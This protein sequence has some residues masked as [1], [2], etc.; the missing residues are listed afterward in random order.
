MGVLFSECNPFLLSLHFEN[1]LITSCVF[2]D[3]SL[4]RTNFQQCQIDE[5]DF[6]NTDLTEASFEGSDLERTVFENSNLTRTSFVN[7]DNYAFD[8]NKNILKKT[9][10]SLPGALSLL[11]SFDV[12]IEP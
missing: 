11:Y 2:S 9:R 12:V 7:A 10:L 6:I 4:I 1:C 5:C 8:P 3:L